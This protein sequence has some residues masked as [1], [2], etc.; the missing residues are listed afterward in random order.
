MGIVSA[1]IGTTSLCISGIVPWAIY[2]TVWS[3]WLTGD[4]SG[5]LIVTPLILVWSQTR[6]FKW[7]LNALAEQVFI[8]I[9]I[10]FFSQA[11]FLHKYSLTDITT[12]IYMLVPFL[13]WMVFRFGHKQIIS[14]LSIISAFAIWGTVHGAGP[15]IS[16]SLNDSLLQLIAFISIITITFMALSASLVESKRTLLVLQLHQEE[17]EIKVAQRTK[18]I[19]ETNRR[20]LAEV[21]D[22]QKAQL[23]ISNKTRQLAEAQSQA[24]IGSWDWDV[25]TDII[26]WSDELYN[27]YGLNLDNFIPSYSKFLDFLHPEDKKYVNA[28]M[29][30]ALLKRRISIS[31]IR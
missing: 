4:A 29:K 23:A 2:V 16:P 27:I 30:M 21:Q 15:F 17:L 20:L 3:T 19:E 7:K 28:V 14:L 26:T 18:D 11:I 24:H 10:I 12:R 5:V 8:T 9:I 31:F 6:V 13:L 22:R 1:T 25:K